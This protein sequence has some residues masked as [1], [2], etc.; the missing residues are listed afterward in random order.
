[1]STND[2]YVQRMKAKMDEWNAKLNM[3]KAQAE[4]ASADTK[5]KINEQIEKLESRRAEAKMKLKELQ[6]AGEGAWQDLRKGVDEAWDSI[7]NALDDA[8]KKFK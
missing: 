3:L 6:N 2:A 1:M 8:V 4:G 7:S 5:I